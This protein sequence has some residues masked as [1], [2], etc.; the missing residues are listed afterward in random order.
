ME[1]EPNVAPK[2]PS[3][4]NM[5]HLEHTARALDRAGVSSRAGADILNSYAMDL[6]LL[7]EETKLTMTVDKKKLDRWRIKGRKE[8]REKEEKEISSRPVQSL[9]FDGEK[10]ASL[11]QI[12]KNGKHYQRTVIEDYYVM[13][14]EPESVFLGH[15]VPFSGHGISIGL[16]L[17]RFLKSKGWHGDIFVVGADGCN[18]NVGKDEGA[19]PYL[20][21]LIG[22]PLHWFI[23]QLHGNELPFRALVRFLD[24]GTSG[25]LSL[26]GEVG[27]TLNDD[28]TM[29]KIVR[30]QRIPFSDFPTVAEDASYDLSNDQDYLYC[31]CWGII[32]GSI[33]PELASRQPGALNHS[34]WLTLAN[35]I[36]R[37]YA[38]T[39]NPS[40]KLKHLVTAI[41]KFYA[42]SWFHIKTH[43]H[44]IDGP[45]NLLKMIQLSKNLTESEQ[46]VA[47]KAIQR[48]AFFGQPEQV[49]LTMLN[50]K[51]KEIRKRAV[52]KIVSLRQ[53]KA[54]EEEELN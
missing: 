15:K 44:C 13:L 16:E 43:P 50:D 31:M 37:K 10:D 4:R 41:I 30:F 52:D 27:V 24:G 14:K 48:N 5:H 1:W 49:L 54:A 47:H 29:L 23:C 42:P 18:V 8:I 51:E 35:R 22:W 32:E 36:L 20:E 34:R 21:K 6:G 2:I 11:T 26:K 45:K 3:Q 9:Y 40:Q 25:P 28:L 39:S 19:L 33:S 7:T 46:K 53:T 17:Y 38:S 12:E